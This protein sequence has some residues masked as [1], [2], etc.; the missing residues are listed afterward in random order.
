M[1]D[2]LKIRVKRTQ[3][4]RHPYTATA[5]GF[6]TYGWGHTSAEARQKLIENIETSGEKQAV[7]RYHRE[8]DAEPVA[9]ACDDRPGQGAP[10]AAESAAGETLAIEVETEVS[11]RR[12]RPI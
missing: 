11:L 12:R 7:G 3:N 4:G 1:T 8:G 2:N 6:A 10:D 5:R 9:S